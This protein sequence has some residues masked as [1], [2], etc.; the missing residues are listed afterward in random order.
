MKGMKSQISLKFTFMFCVKVP[1]EVGG[2]IMVIRRLGVV[3]RKVECV[4]KEYILKNEKERW[5]ELIYYGN[6]A[7]NNSHK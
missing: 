7:L 3:I 2:I 6:I 4:Y 1:L 5:L